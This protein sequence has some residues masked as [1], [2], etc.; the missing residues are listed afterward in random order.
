MK[1]ACHFQ[2]EAETK[3]IKNKCVNGKVILSLKTYNQR[4]HDH[5]VSLINTY[6]HTYTRLQTHPGDFTINQYYTVHQ[7]QTGSNCKYNQSALLNISMGYTQNNAVIVDPKK[8]KENMKINV[9]KRLR[10]YL[11]YT[12]FTYV[13]TYAYIQH[14]Y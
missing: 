5:I 13:H 9:R 6:I 1:R 2:M 3:S 11:W 10:A 8:N 12:L 14:I 4:W 7:P